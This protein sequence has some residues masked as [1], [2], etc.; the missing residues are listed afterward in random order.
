M[1]VHIL[2]SATGFPNAYQIATEDTPVVLPD[3]GGP[4]RPDRV[5]ADMV[6][7]TIDGGGAV[8]S[9]GSI[10]YAGGLAWNNFD[11]DLSTITTRVLKSFCSTLPE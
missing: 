8:F 2:A 6:Y 1:E 7:F 11:N 4:F 5:R 9:V 10:C 3:Q